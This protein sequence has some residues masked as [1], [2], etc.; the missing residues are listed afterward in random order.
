MLRRLLRLDEDRI[1][2]EQLRLLLGTVGISVVPAIFLSAVLVW[3]LHRGDN[4]PGLVLWALGVS[5]SKLLNAYHARRILN[6]GMPL[7]GSV[8]LVCTLMLLNAVD[9]VLW[10][11]LTWVTLRQESVVGTVLVLTVM[12]GVTSNA[13]SVLAPVLPVFLAFCLSAVALVSSKLMLTN[14]P[15]YHTLAYVTILYVATHVAQGRIA[16][17]AARA[18]INL[19]FENLDLIERLRGQTERAQVAHQR[20]EDANLAKSKFL[21]AA[22]H[23]LRQPIHAVG[24]FLEVIGR[25]ELNALQREMLE[26]ARGTSLASADMLNTLLDFSRIEA[27]VIQPILQPVSLQRVLSKVESEMAPQATGKGL[28]YRTRETN[29]SATADPMLLELILRNLVSNA[30][31]YTSSG[32]LLVGCRRRG[33]AVWLE[34]WDTGMGLAADQYGE[35]FREFHQ[36]GNPERD[37]KKG[38]GLGLAIVDR[39]VRQMGLQLA[40]KSTLGRGSVFRIELPWCDSAAVAAEPELHYPASTPLKLSVLVIEDDDAVRLGMA[41]L[42]RHWGCDCVAVATIEA[43]QEAAGSKRPDLVISDYRLKEQRTGA[44]AIAALRAQVGSELPALI[45]TG[46]TAPERLRDAKATGIPLLHKPVSPSILYQRLQ[47]IELSLQP[48]PAK[49][50]P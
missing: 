37:R 22:S 48:L 25:G 17:N 9:G 50:W 43:A 29:L 1:L 14:D 18:A 16:A 8:S 49:N 23:D 35:I 4:L 28:F 42:L 31:R 7:Q 40:L 44:Q 19:R 11:A 41:Q 39:L 46:D 30:V 27:G 20:A 12:A 36:L 32:G 45:I 38:L 47:E 10:G 33:A 6:N 24:L 15:E 21:A 26:N 34:V 2:R 3:A 13:M 5:G